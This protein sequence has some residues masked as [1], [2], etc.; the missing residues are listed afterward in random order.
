MS[1]ELQGGVGV[2]NAPCG[3][4]IASHAPRTS[5]MEDVVMMHDH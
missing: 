3:I 4:A 1:V 5:N 2:V